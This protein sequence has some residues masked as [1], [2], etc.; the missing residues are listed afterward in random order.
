MNNRI[1]Y[2]WCRALHIYLSTAL[3]TLLVFFCIT[4]F[5]LNHLDWLPNGKSKGQQ[6]G[7]LPQAIEQKF[8][9]DGVSQA[10][11]LVSIQQHL[12]EEFDLTRLS[13]VDWDNDMQELILDYPMPAGY[14]LVIVNLEDFHY[15]V[16]HQQGDFTKIINDLHKG[17]HSGAFWS[18]LIDAS[19]LLI[20]IFSLTGLIIL[21]QNK[22][23][24]RSGLWLTLL[25][26]CSP[27]I[28]Y[29]FF[30]PRLAGI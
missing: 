12:L 28:I 3:F 24:R 29:W 8:K 15:V 18:I 4:G 25:G 10:Q 13:Q 14:A 26:T 2:A 7:Q 19:A 11:L 9:Q 20:T 1:F 23:K 6:Q 30:V 5:L 22:N 21:F 16:E 17:R 27:F